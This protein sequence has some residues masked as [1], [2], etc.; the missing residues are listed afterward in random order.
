MKSIRILLLLPL[1]LS[2]ETEF[3]GYFESEGDILQQGSEQYAFGYHKLRVDL[4]TR[5]DDQV[6]IGMN[7]N[8][9]RF[10]GQT[11]WNLLDF[12]PESV[13]KP[14]FQDPAFPE[15]YWISSIPF[16]LPDTV[17]LDNF[18]LRVSLGR[19]DVTLG[20]Q[21]ISPGVAYA[22]NPTDIFN[23]KTLLDPGYE[24]TGVD[25]IRTE[26]TLAH[27]LTL[28]TVYQPED[29][30]D[31][32]T[33]Q[34]FLKTGWGAFDFILTRA[35]YPWKRTRMLSVNPLPV[36]MDRELTGISV[37]GELLGCGVWLEGGHNE[38]AH[39]S[40][41]DELVLGMDHTFDNSL[42]ILLETLQ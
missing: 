36:A 17:L 34:F 24:Q 28:E 35:A 26:I 42:Y 30:W 39:D 11:T 6:L 3:F 19:L 2:A 41:F 21:Q 18:Y 20:R 29:T 27:R 4:E 12:L 25:V 40:A 37:V 31:S 16:T 23:S 5:P 33:R 15:T 7:V 38:L 32:S 14:L 10:W 13:W 9:Q 8:I 22:W 1:L